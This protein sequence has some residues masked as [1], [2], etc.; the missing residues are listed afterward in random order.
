MTKNRRLAIALWSLGWMLISS[1]G[2]GAQEPPTL[3][4]L[5]AAA[6]KLADLTALRPYVLRAAV[7]AKPGDKD[8]ERSGQL[9]IYRD[10]DRARVELSLGSSRETRIVLGQ[11]Q[12]IT[13]EA[14]LFPATGLANFDS[15]WLLAPIPG[16]TRIPLAKARVHGG[17]AWCAEM[18]KPG[19]PSRV[20]F[21]AYDA[22]RPKLISVQRVPERDEFFTY[23]LVDQ[24]WFPGQ[25]WISR[26]DATLVEV[27]DVQVLPGPLEATLFDVPAGSVEIESCGAPT[28]KPTYHFDPQFPES[29]SKRKRNGVV[30]L[31]LV[32]DKEGRLAAARIVKTTSDAFA[33]QSLETVQKW[34]FQA[35]MCG[36]RPVNQEITVSFGFSLY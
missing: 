21:D 26:Q 33:H 30:E 24:R 16:A 35:G 22:T 23:T 19:Y 15:S 4:Q 13:L 31:S 6:Y 3:Q 27:R 17:D 28:A 11:R 8:Q 10:R 20:C 34:K 7:T 14:A 32:I 1:N 18:E 9:T 29:E 25:A 12:Y 36:E 5:A 2:L